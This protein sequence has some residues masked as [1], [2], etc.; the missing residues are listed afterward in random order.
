MTPNRM[1]KHDDDDD[2]DDD[3]DLSAIP[4]STKVTGAINL[5]SRRRRRRE[6]SRGSA[7]GVG[8]GRVVSPARI[9]QRPIPTNKQPSVAREEVVQQSS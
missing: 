5:L 6:G 4:T 7:V 9:L 2:S 8:R 3:D 1:G